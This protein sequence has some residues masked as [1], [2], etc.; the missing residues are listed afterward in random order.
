V[1]IYHELVCTSSPA[2]HAFECAEGCGRLLVVDRGTGAMT[3]LGRGDPYA[4]HRGSSDDLALSAS[5]RPG[6]G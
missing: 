5:V 1:E 3:V 4:L 6:E 2:G